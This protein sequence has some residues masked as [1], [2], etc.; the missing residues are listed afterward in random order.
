MLALESWE[1]CLPP[2]LSGQPS[3]RFF[4]IHVV[5]AGCP[6]PVLGLMGT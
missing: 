5:W 4:P 3:W 2:S 6:A 1:P